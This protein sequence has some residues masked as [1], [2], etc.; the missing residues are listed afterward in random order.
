MVTGCAPFFLLGLVGVALG[1]L[2]FG[3]HTAA[4]LTGLGLLT[5]FLLYFALLNWT[6]QTRMRH[7]REA[8][9]EETAPPPREGPAAA[10]SE[11]EDPAEWAHYLRTEGK[12]LW[13]M[14]FFLLAA[15]LFLSL[16]R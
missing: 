8:G 11:E 6:A 13:G 2:L 10:E 5:L 7:R 1:S 14:V 3:S 9:P 15:I 4:R 16:K 12:V